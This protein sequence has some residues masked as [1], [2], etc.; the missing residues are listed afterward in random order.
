MTRLVFSLAT[1][2]YRQT[3]H[4][5]LGICY[6]P[7]GTDISHLCSPL[8]ALNLS[9]F[10]VLSAPVCQSYSSQLSQPLVHVIQPLLIYTH[11]W[12][13]GLGAVPL[14]VCWVLPAD[15]Y[16]IIPQSSTMLYCLGK[17]SV[18]NPHSPWWRLWVLLV[19]WYS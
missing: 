18:Y 9:H 7:D 19:V 10:N 5:T 2:F 17:D 11:R 3:V 1:L 15:F 6:S 8:D 14:L 12:S 16:L 13:P 4:D